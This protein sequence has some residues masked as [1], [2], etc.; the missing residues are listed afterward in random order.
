MALL[1]SLFFLQGCCLLFECPCHYKHKVYN[2]SG[3]TLECRLISAHRDRD[4]TL[5]PDEKITF[6][7][8]TEL[9]V[10]RLEERDAAFPG[11]LGEWI[12]CPLEITPEKEIF[13]TEP[14]Y[15]E[16]LKSPRIKPVYL[17]KDERLYWWDL[18]ET[19]L[20]ALA[21]WQQRLQTWEDPTTGLV[22]RYLPEGEQ[23]IVDSAGPLH[24]GQTVEVPATLGGLPVRAIGDGAF[25]G[26]K[27]KRVI[28]PQEVETLGRKAFDSCHLEEITLP[29][30][31]KHIG[32]GAFLNASLKVLCLP[33]GLETIGDSAFMWCINLEHVTIP[34]SV[35]SLGWKAFS[36][37]ARL[38]TI[39]FEGP[40]PAGE[41][42]VF[43]SAL[44]NAEAIGIYPEA[45]AAAWEAVIQEGSWRGLRM[46]KR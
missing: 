25:S 38:Q 4:V 24:F 18:V 11:I 43:T 31:L 21:A 36:Q 19:R 7:Y 5:Q 15:Q 10:I 39:T 44:E 6:D 42:E 26:G 1:G 9:F 28:L 17:P 14:R 16:H 46:E 13:V 29:E 32:D 34:S 37:C 33:E 20:G 22:W 30:R 2:R 40:P 3:E 41:G 8:C 12:F 23:A 45:H 27:A 35:T